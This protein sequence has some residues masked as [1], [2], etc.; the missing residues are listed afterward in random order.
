MSS[1]KIRNEACSI[2]VT[3]WTIDGRRGYPINLSNFLK[4]YNIII[5]YPRRCLESVVEKN[6]ERLVRDFASILY[7]T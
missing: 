2:D 5:G 7:H 3:L 4:L 1:F 6:D